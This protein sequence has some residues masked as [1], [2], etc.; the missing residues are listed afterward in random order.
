MAFARSAGVA[1]AAVGMSATALVAGAAQLGDATGAPGAGDRYFPRYGNGGYDVRHYDIFV[2]YNPTTERLHGDTRLTARAEQRLTRFHLDLQIPAK[3]VRVNGEPATWRQHGRELVISPAAALRKGKAFR[4]RV[5][6]AGK[7]GEINSGGL[8]GWFETSDGAVLAGEPEAATLWFPSND[9]PS[10]KASFDIDVR[11]ARGTDVVSNGRLTGR[12]PIGDEVVWRWRMSSPMATYLAY[13]AFG[14]F[15]FERGR[16]AG[17]VPYLYAISDHLGKRRASAV[18]S[19]RKSADIVD[20][21]SR[22]FGPYPFDITG[23]TLANVNFGFALENQTRPIY[24]KVFFGGKAAN[25]NVIAHELAHQWFG[26][27]VSVQQWR[28]I[29]LNEG[30]A[31]W[32]AWFYEAHR[33]GP[34]TDEFFTDAYRGFRKV[35]S[36]WRLEIGNPG[37]Q[38]LFD[39]AV[40]LRGAMALE[41][42][43]N[44]VG[45]NDFFRTMRSWV[46]SRGDGDGSIAGFQRLAERISERPLDHVFDVWLH[47][48]ARPRPTKANGFPASML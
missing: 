19:L 43:R 32:C 22:H 13:V 24:S 37:K 21:F 7:P 35:R 28:Y 45:N 17:G 40:Y 6:Y 4:V 8:G 16:T 5:R 48:T 20:M 30:F 42:V 12:R 11:T 15:S 26:D 3:A 44:V 25:I 31:T 2:D 41:A 46:R 38:R 1:L 39:F 27:D 9:H 18:K 14:D 36:F 23:G 47:S 29:W 10:D 34:S 33:A